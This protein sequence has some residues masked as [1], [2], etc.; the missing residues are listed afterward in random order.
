MIHVVMAS[1]DNY[2]HHLAVAAMSC[3][4]RTSEDVTLHV[5]CNNV[6]EENKRKLTE[7]LQAVKANQKINFIDLD[8]KSLEGLCGE[9]FISVTMY[10][11]YFIPELIPDADKALYLDTDILVRHDISPLWEMDVSDY[12]IAAAL[13]PFIAK[14][15]EGYGVP[16]GTPMFN[17]GVM[18]MNLKKWREADF[19]KKALEYSLKTGHNDQTTLN[20]ILSG[21]WL[22]IDPKYNVLTGYYRSYYKFVPSKNAVLPAD[23][24]TLIKDPAVLHTNGKTKLLDYGYRYFFV[25]EY[26]RYLSMTPWRDKKPT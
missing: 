13:D 17:S 3:V 9:R 2:I 25:D 16:K 8:A 7:S 5:L 10:A 6:S 19:G 21:D 12:L 4:D 24:K 18:L 14:Y 15:Y 20:S 1:D 23:I 26:R 22:P 11:R